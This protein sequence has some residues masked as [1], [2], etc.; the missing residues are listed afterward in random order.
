[1]SV[2]LVLTEPGRETTAHASGHFTL[3]ELSLCSRVETG[4]ETRFEKSWKIPWKA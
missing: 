3:D 4:G 1:V 2:K